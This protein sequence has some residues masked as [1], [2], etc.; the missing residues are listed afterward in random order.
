MTFLKHHLV[1]PWTTIFFILILS[2]FGRAHPKTNQTNPTL[3]FEISFPDSAHAGPITGRVYVFITRNSEREPRFQFG[4]TGVP[5]FGL[6]VEQLKP[7]QPAIIDETV[8]GS[9]VESIQDI[10]AGEY[11]VQ[12]FINIYTEFRRSDGHVVWFHDDQWEGQRFRISPGNLYS[13]IFKVRLDPNENVTIR[14]AAIHVI[15]PIQVPPD[16]KWV[17]RI[18]FQSKLLSDFWGRPIYLGATVL[19]PK[20]Y[21]ENKKTY[22]PVDYIQGHFSL[23]APKGFRTE[24]P[25]ENDRRGKRGY[26]FYETWIADDCPRMILVTFQHPCPYFDDSYAVNSA[27]CGPYGDAIM[28]ELIPEI[29]SRFRIIRKPYAR[30]LEGG[31]TGGW[32][33]LALQT[34][35]P[36]FFGGCFAYCPDPVDF[37]DVQG[38]N[39]YEDKNVYTRQLDWRKVPIPYSR[40]ADGS[41]IATSEQINKYELVLGT[42]G[43]SAE[44]WDIWQAVYGPVGEDG[45]TKPLYDKQTGDID[46]D[47]AQYWKENYDLKVFLEKN[48]ASVGPKLMGKLYVFT[49]DMDTYYLN[50]GVHLLQDFMK[51]TRDPHY[52]GFFWYGPRK[53]HCWTGPFTPLERLEFMADHI[54]RNAPEGEDTSWRK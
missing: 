42:K 14:L 49:G 51:T 10:P 52:E 28:N 5:I 13:D 41:I 30:V 46:P 34:F 24:P 18:K 37:R 45:Y 53:T 22:Y 6:D 19:L 9:P 16:T 47:V 35:H 33:A 26:E 2:S 40:R 1:G 38:I 36:D 50:N 39:I 44:Q 15:P 11:Y 54:A 17:K 7:G 8:L 27:N 43:R 23:R 20:G 21:D 32:E 31:S 25:D 4:R 48:W 12:G 3:T 29:E